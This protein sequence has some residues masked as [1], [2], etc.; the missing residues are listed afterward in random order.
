MKYFV[1]T[2]SMCI[3]LIGCLYSTYSQASDVS[4]NEYSGII[5]IINTQADNPDS[6]IVMGIPFASYKT[7]E[8]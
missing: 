8:P 5:K 4:L 2:L 3:I 1:K 6:V 7:R